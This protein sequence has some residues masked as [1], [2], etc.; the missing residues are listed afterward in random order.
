MQKLQQEMAEL[1]A[2]TELRKSLRRRLN[3]ISQ[4]ASSEVA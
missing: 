3:Q 4:P 1:G 2:L